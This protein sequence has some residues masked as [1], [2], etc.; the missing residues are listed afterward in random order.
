MIQQPIKS[1]NFSIADF[2]SGPVG[3]ANPACW[4]R[5]SVGGWRTPLV[6]QH[7]S[8]SVVFR[9]DNNAELAPLAAGF[10]D[11]GYFPDG[12]IVDRIGLGTVSHAEPA[13]LASDA[14]YLND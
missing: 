10:L 14:I 7:H 1:G 13:P 4:Q 5:H 12:V 9:A 2:G 3:K 8:D 6:A 11:N